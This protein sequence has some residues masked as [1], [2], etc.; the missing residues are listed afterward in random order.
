MINRK[1]LIKP[2]FWL[3]AFGILGV[4]IGMGMST[5]TSALDPQDKQDQAGG[6]QPPAKNVAA[7]KAAAAAMGIPAPPADINDLSMEVA[8]LRTLYLFNVWQDHNNGSWK[9]HTNAPWVY[10]LDEAR[11][12]NT[13]MPA[14]DRKPATGE[15]P[16]AIN[17]Y[18]R[19]LAELRIA[20]IAGQ[21]DRIIDLTD[22][23][24]ELADDGDI[25]LD[26]GI[27]LT[28][29]AKKI[30][31]QT[32]YHSTPECIVNYLNSYG[33]EFPSPINMIGK[34]FIERGPSQKISKETKAFMLK[35][36]SWQLCGYPHY[37]TK[38][39]KKEEDLEKKEKE[40]KQELEKR[41]GALID[42][43][44]EMTPEKCKE[45]WMAKGSLR[46]EYDK[47]KREVLGAENPDYF[48]VLRHVIQQDMAELLSNP[49]L[50]PAM[51]ARVSYLKKAGFINN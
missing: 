28:V 23:L 34:A 9:Y 22:Q 12:N 6:N 36:L 8:A 32:A 11:N 24:D 4:G 51:E 38:D 35:E 27:T 26:D 39:K 29:N 20:Y 7:Q 44:G 14:V 45:E 42:K 46:T 31:H 43:A 2:L 33:K 15:S 49:R 17:N 40:R 19:V 16:D 41:M 18:K 50:I 48:D 30:C 5:R 25:E 10:I 3:G 47:M 1:S 37:N 21:D 13:A